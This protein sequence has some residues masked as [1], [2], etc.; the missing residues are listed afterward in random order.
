MKIVSSRHSLNKKARLIWVVVASGVVGSAILLSTQAAINSVSV[1]LENSTKIGCT[2]NIDSTGASGGTAVQFGCLSNG[3]EVHVYS[4]QSIDD[5]VKSAPA[6]ATVLIH[7]GS[8]PGVTITNV[9]PSSNITVKG[10]PNET[11][12][13]AGI[14]MSGSSNISIG[15]FITSRSVAV[16]NSTNIVLTGITAVDT[17]VDEDK[18]CA[19]SPNAFSICGTSNNIILENSVAKVTTF[20][21]TVR[22]FRGLNLYGCNCTDKAQWPK[23]IIVRNNDFSATWDDLISVTGV[24]N[25]LVENNYLHDHRNTQDRPGDPLNYYHQD[26]LQVNRAD[27]VKILRN[28]FVAR[29]LTSK[30]DQGIIISGSEEI[31]KVKNVLIANNLI[32]HWAGSGITISGVMNLDIVNNTSVDNITDTGQSF[33]IFF[34]GGSINTGKQINVRMWNNIFSKVGFT[35]GHSYSSLTLASNNMVLISGQGGSN[36]ITA[37]PDFVSTDI[38]S[39]D[40]YKLKSTSAARSAGLVNAQT[41]IND[42]INKNRDSQPE[43]GAFEY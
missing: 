29:D 21:T 26:G 38:N 14:S 18:L 35:D 36:Q 19:V 31:D 3:P 28:T 41:P 11:V 24:E 22:N 1:E 6:G 20:D 7:A 2:Q 17:L 32:H 39:P 15:N 37:R 4:G 33:G 23:N 8:F 12:K 43:V 42:R 40:A 9:K 16:S 13:I 34:T 30:A 25:L 27:G 10:A 5:A